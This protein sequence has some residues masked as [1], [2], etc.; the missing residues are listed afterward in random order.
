[1]GIRER[2]AGAARAG[3]NPYAS[4]AYTPDAVAGPGRDHG[5]M[6]TP[7]EGFQ[8][9]VW[10]QG[11]AVVVQV[12]DRDMHQ[13][14]G[15]IQVRTHADVQRIMD[16]YGIPAGRWDREDRAVALLDADSADP[17]K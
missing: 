6:S 17:Q 7:D 8:I 1:M 9:A 5:D 3:V 12:Y 11:A 2:V 10:S 13:V 16:D 15:E 14:D 4:V